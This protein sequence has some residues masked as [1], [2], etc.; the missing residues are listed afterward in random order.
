[1]EFGFSPPQERFRTFLS[2]Q[3]WQSRF[4]PA[5]DYLDGLNW[6]GTRRID[7]WLFDYAGISRRAD[8]EDYNRYV[9]P[10]A[11]LILVAG[12]RRIRQPGCK[13]DEMLVLINELQGT[14]KS[15]ALA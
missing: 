14:D 6:D 10:V 8:D 4:H 12:V 1:E 13:F 11:R 3:A 5:R 2:D 9:A 15:T 7:T